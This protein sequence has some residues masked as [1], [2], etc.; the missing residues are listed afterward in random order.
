MFYQIDIDPED[1]VDAPK[2]KIPENTLITM[3]CFVREGDKTNSK[4][5]SAIP[6][7]L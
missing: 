6:V 3:T 5:C 1:F 2:L 7:S 4:K